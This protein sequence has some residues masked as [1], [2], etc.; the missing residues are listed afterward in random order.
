MHWKLGFLFMSFTFFSSK[1]AISEEWGG[2]SLRLTEIPWQAK[3]A[4]AL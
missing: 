4:V 2:G 1:I 3:M